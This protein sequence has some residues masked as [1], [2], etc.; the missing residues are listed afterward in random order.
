MGDIEEHNAVNESAVYNYRL[1]NVGLLSR[2]QDAGTNDSHHLLFNEL[3]GGQTL[4]PYIVLHQLGW[5]ASFS[6]Y[7][8]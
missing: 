7:R 8:R 5:W 2:A 3:I 4:S 6:F 1:L